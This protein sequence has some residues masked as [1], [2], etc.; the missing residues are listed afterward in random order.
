MFR[1]ISHFCVQVL[2]AARV[3]STT[4]G[5]VFTGV[6]LLRGRGT[7]VF[8]PKSLLRERYPSIWSQVPSGEGAVSGPWSIMGGTP[9]QHLG[10]PTTQQYRGTPWTDRG[11]PWKDRNTLLGGNRRTQHAAGGTPLT[12]TQDDCLVEFISSFHK[13]PYLTDLTLQLEKITFIPD[14]C[15]NVSYCKV[16]VHTFGKRFVCVPHHEVTV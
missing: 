10:V 3:R 6:C 8:G 7:P 2:I 11:A 15:Q 12:V 5:Y 13:H 4:E 1:L 16:R 14:Q 9:G